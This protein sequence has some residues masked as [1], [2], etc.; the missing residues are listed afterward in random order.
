MEI[1]SRMEPVSPWGRGQARG[2]SK[3]DKWADISP[4]ESDGDLGADM[5]G[6]WWKLEFSSRQ[7]SNNRRVWGH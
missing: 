2:W 3:E 6:L 5:S 1:V 7:D 4:T